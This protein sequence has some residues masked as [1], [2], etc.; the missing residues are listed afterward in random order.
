[1]LC[2]VGGCSFCMVVVFVVVCDFGLFC[3]CLVV[4]VCGIGGNF[5]CVGG[6]GSSTKTTTNTTNNY[7]VVVVFVVVGVRGHFC[8]SFCGVARCWRLL[9]LCCVVLEVV[10]FVW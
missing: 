6:R 1:V 4:I 10:I 5:C 2:G 8:C 7:H 3:L 9:F